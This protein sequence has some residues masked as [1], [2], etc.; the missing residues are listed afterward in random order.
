[1]RD[2][3][4]PLLVLHVED[5]ER[6]SQLTASYLESNDV[7]VV[8]VA[9]G[10]EALARAPRLRPDV[11]LLDVG[12]PG[13]DGVAV[14]RRL[15]DELDTPILMVT[16]H[17]AELDR[18]LGLQAGA[19]DYVVKPFSL[20]ELLARV[21][22]HARRA[23]G[24]LTASVRTLVVGPLRIDTR[25]MFATLD[26]RPLALTAYE[27]ALLRALAERAGRTLTREELMDLVKGSADES[28]DRS[29]DV[30]VS[31]LRKKLCDDPR[32][33]RLL[34]TVRGV[35]YMLVAP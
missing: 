32:D 18:V 19:D 35:G 8:T 17:D 28:F 22:A 12:L 21:Q 4:S 33:P 16:A 1:V 14:C 30:H 11:I 27:F 6:L 2:D 9:S 20:A 31:N 23:R 34:K 24:T 3:P 7:R 29:V 15:R 5:D 13:M 25:A 26:E 10:S